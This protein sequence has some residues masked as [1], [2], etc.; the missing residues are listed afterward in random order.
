[1]KDKKFMMRAIELAKKAK[2]KTYPNPMVGAVLVKDDKIVGEGYHKKSGM[3]HAEI[4]ALQNAKKNSKGATLYVTLEPCAHHGKTPPCVDSI[5]SHGVRKVFAAMTD[6]NPLVN[7]K[8]FKFLRKEGIKTKVGVC[9]NEA[10]K[11]NKVY[12]ESFK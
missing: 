10:K 4:I 1:M 2:G 7:G 3:P 12:I 6:P 11:L 9:K 5:T 8:G